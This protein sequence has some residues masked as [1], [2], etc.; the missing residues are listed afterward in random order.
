M[1][2]E[3]IRQDLGPM[4]VGF[5]LVMG[6]LAV[7]LRIIRR[8]PGSSGPETDHLPRL[9]SRAQPGWPRLVIFWT[10]TAVSGYL[11]LMAIVVLY[12][13]GVARVGG[14]FLESAFTGCAMLIGLATPVFAALSWLAARKGWRF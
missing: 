6:S 8:S 3:L 2:A 13:Y 10:A 12:Y 1:S 9:V 11:L 7:G 14:A 5:L 4:V